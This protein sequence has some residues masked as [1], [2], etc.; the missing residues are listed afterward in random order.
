MITNHV[1]EK[2]VPIPP[3]WMVDISNF[4]NTIRTKEFQRLRWISQLGILKL[5]YPG[6]THSRIEH[7][8]GT[9]YLTTAI[10]KQLGLKEDEA[11]TFRAYG[12]LHDIGHLPFSHQLEPLLSQNHEQYGLAILSSMQEAIEKDGIDYEK[13]VDIFKKKH[14]IVSDKNLGPDKL[15]YLLRDGLHM[16]F[17]PIPHVFTLI[18]YMGLNGEAL[19]I[20]EKGA[21]SAKR[22][23][24]Y[25]ADMHM[26]GYLCKQGM[27]SQRMLQRSLEEAL[28][29][30][31]KIE[32]YSFWNMMDDDV[33]QI[34]KDSKN[35][36]AKDLID[37]LIYRGVYKTAVVFK[38]DKFKH[39]ERVID[40]PIHVEG[41]TQDKLENFTEVYS[42]PQKL[43][44]L[45]NEVAKEIGVE[46]GTL[47]IPLIP[48][49]RMLPKDIRVYNKVSSEPNTLFKLYPEHEKQLMERY[50]SSFAIRIATTPEQRKEVYEKRRE[51][52]GYIVS[53]VLK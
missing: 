9:L 26:E 13:L 10:C 21:L 46:E 27:I 1:P 37:A 35:K 11:K 15:D 38:I 50:L 42:S 12:L 25:Y 22:L 52:V 4:K 31:G 18:Q 14:P 16:G 5:V 47:L 29:E 17:D 45:E 33:L 39:S 36:L 24:D 44:E 28:S 53:S 48:L 49:K 19:A 40:K 20:E 34:L 41:I 30:T 6:A 43:S 32:Q 2:A 51:I 7:S 23:Q 8:F 3:D